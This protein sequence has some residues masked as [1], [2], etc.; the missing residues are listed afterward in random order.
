MLKFSF[1][2][3]TGDIKKINCII[4]PVFKCEVGV[5]ARD[6]FTRG[7]RGKRIKESIW[8]SIS[9]CLLILLSMILKWGLGQV[10]YNIKILGNI[11]SG[12][13]KY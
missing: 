5:G 4:G 11:H 1:I 8:I 3:L 2:D 6:I 13:K 7:G 9:I 10:F 12:A